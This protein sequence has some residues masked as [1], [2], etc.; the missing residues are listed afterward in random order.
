MS[1]SVFSFFSVFT[2]LYFIL[3]TTSY[4]GGIKRR[5]P[6]SVCLS[7][8]YL[9]RNRKRKLKSGRMEAHAMRDP[10]PHLEV[11][12]SKVKVTRS[13]VKTV[14]TVSISKRGQQ[15]LAFEATPT[16]SGATW[17]TGL[18]ISVW[19]VKNK[20]EIPL[21]CFFCVPAE[22]VPS[23]LGKFGRPQETRMM[24]LPWARKKFDD[25]FSRLD[26]IYECDRRTPPDSK[27]RALYA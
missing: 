14:K 6:L 16:A 9:T 5:W 25:I 15:L 22:G 24:W 17:R 10:W 11:E 23:E 7:V 26:R 2:I 3:R 4:G 1:I 12:R 20:L 21:P 27:D 13:Q 19:S 18:Q 8:P